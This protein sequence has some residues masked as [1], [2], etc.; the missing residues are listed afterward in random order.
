MTCGPLVFG[1]AFAGAVLGF[2]IAVILCAGLMK[3]RRAR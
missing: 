1:I 3:R 2:V